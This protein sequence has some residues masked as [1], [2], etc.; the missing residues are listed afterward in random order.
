MINGRNMT[1][2]GIFR[3]YAETYLEKHPLINKDMMIMCRQLDPTSQGI[4]VEVYVFSKDKDWKKYEHLM[5]D[6]FDHLL[7]SVNFF[8][9]ECFELSY[10]YSNLKA[11]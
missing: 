1:N 7:A 8:K 6:I 4:P 2:L 11:K 5:S 3:R 10:N 9:L